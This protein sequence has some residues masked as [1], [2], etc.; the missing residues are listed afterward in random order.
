MVDFVGS[1]AFDTQVLGRRLGE[2]FERGVLKLS[3]LLDSETRDAASIDA[4]KADLC[5]QLRKLLVSE[6]YPEAQVTLR[7][8]DERATR[9]LTFSLREGQQLRVEA[10]DLTGNKSLTAAEL[11]GPWFERR[12]GLEGG[13]APPF[14]ATEIDA[15]AKEIAARY[16]AAG[17]LE[18]TTSTP[19]V[20]RSGASPLV[21]VAITVTEGPLYTILRTRVDRSLAAALGE[22]LPSGLDGKPFSTSEVENYRRELMRRLRERGHADPSTSV[23]LG[24]VE[25]QN[26]VDVLVRGEAG[27][28]REIGA[29]TVRGNKKIRADN[30]LATAGLSVG[31][32]FRGSAEDRALQRLHASNNFARIKVLHEDAEDGRLAVV[33]EVVE[34]ERP[35]LD[36]EVGYGSYV[37]ARV[38]L[39]VDVENFA[40]TG[41][42]LRTLGEVHSRGHVVSAS[43][44]RRELFENTRV[45][46]GLAH[47]RRRQPSFSDQVLAAE[48]AFQYSLG[49]TSELSAGYRFEDHGNSWSDTKQADLDLA[50]HERSVVF[51]DWK[52]VDRDHPVRSFDGYKAKL[53][54]EW[55]EA[56]LGGDVDLLAVGV[57]IAR[58]MRLGDR[59]AVS[60]RWRSGLLWSKSSAAIPIQHRMFAGGEDSV[61]SFREDRLGPKDADGESIGGEYRN[62]FNLEG[63]FVLDDP[64]DLIVF[65]DAGNVGRRAEDFDLDGMRYAVGLGLQYLAPVQ[66][67]LRLDFAVNPDRRSGEE[68]WVLHLRIGLLD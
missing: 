38:G 50:D 5:E 17:Y 46:L 25:E 27:P 6:G 35:P 40:A 3:T 30:I 39:R 48:L 42:D 20:V 62:V 18:A 23:V 19:Q 59:V 65:A 58:W 4:A 54:L 63:R 55:S 29:V 49:S 24:A 22:E 44:A 12:R 1:K 7:L 21:T 8:E 34:M 28:I 9:T 14:V 52:T 66:L 37:R 36:I 53:G 10:V 51:A 16:Q 67:P 61:R 31:E 15:L 11:T 47:T 13:D 60:A 45:A 64:F 26:G 32:T 68:V 56:S 2:D 33:F 57:D 43:I 41:L